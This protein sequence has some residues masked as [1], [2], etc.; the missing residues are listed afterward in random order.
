MSANKAEAWANLTSAARTFVENESKENSQTLS[1]VACAWAGAKGWRAPPGQ[2]DL[3]AVLPSYGRSKG[4]PIRGAETGDLQWYAKTLRE[5]IENP[6]KARWIESNQ[7]SLSAI[8]QE[9]S[10][11]VSEPEY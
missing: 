7:K 2:A 4:L 1:D 5:S 8:E 3:E 11:R 10:K 9:L 6:A